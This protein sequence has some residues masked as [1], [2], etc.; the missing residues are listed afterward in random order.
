MPDD[1]GILGQYDGEFLRNDGSRIITRLK[2]APIMG[3]EGEYLGSIA[4]VIDIT[5][6]RKAE[7]EVQHLQQQLLQAQ[8]M[9]AI[10]RLAGGVAH[11][12]NNLLTTILG[13]VELIR[14]EKSSHG[15]I[16]DIA[17]EIQKAGLRAAELT[18]QLLAFSRKQMLQPKTLDLNGL[19]KNLS[20][21]LRRLIGEDIALELHLDPGAGSVKADPGQLEQVILNLAV[22]AR[23]AMALGGRLVLKTRNAETARSCSPGVSMFRRA[24]MS[25]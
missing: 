1:A 22:N 19:V 9:E 23:D 5:E 10:G 4:S 16:E 2:M 7:S 14:T 18:H 25:P 12:F 17:L 24:P 11:D 13:N 3:E 6:Q 21:M 20:K 8:K 15:V